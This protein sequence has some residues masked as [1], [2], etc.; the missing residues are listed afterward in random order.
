M[1]RFKKKNNI[2]HINHHYPS[3]T[4]I[5]NHINPHIYTYVDTY[6]NHIQGLCEGI[7]PI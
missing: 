4:I 7:Y 6:R 1:V 5:I 2:N 3:S